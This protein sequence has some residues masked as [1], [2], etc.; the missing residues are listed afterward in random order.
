RTEGA[1]KRGTSYR[2]QDPE[3]IPAHVTQLGHIHLPHVGPEFRQ[4]GETRSA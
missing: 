2:C 3:V 4:T 1:G